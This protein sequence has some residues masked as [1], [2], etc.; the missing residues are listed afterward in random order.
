MQQYP[1]SVCRIFRRDVLLAV[2]NF[3]PLGGSSFKLALYTSDANID[4]DTTTYTTF[5]EIV[6]SGYTAGGIALISEGAILNAQ[7]QGAA[8]FQSP[9]F[10]LA[11]FTC[12]KALIYN[13][14]APG[15]NAVGFIDF[16]IDQ[17]PVG[18]N[19]VINM[20]ILAGPSPLVVIR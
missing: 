13:A 19:F 11:T 3:N 12:R 9:T 4:Q 10:P 6:G 8:S 18:S 15:L 7:G 20:P 5:D 16:G 2:H 17:S 14:S 1:G